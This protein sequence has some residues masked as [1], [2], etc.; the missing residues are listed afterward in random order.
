MFVPDRSRPTSAV[1]RVAGRAGQLVVRWTVTVAV[2]GGFL[3]LLTALLAGQARNFVTA[4]KAGSDVSKIELAPLATRSI[5]YAADGSVIQYLY[6]EQDRLPVSIDKVPPQVVKAVLDAEDDRFFQHGPIDLRAMARAMV[7]NVEAGQIAE[8]GSTITQQL[9]KTALLTPKKNVSRKLQEASLA[10]RLEKQMTKTQILERYLNTVYFG[11]G[12]YGLEAAA[13]VYYQTNV[14]KL[15]QGQG[16]LLAG[17]IRNPVG[18]DPFNNPQAARDRRDAIIDRMV[19]LGDV[20]PDQAV[21]LKAEPLPTPPPAPDTGSSDYF[22]RKVVDD[23]LKDPKYLG[24]TDADRNSLVFRGGISIHTT[25][26]PSAQA[27]AEASITETLPE[28][29][30]QFDAAL[31]SVDPATGAVRAA[32]SGLDFAKDKINLVTGAGRQVGSAFKTF[33][34]M[35]A[36][37]AGDIPADTILGTSPCSIPNP[38]GEDDPWKTQN[39]EG[40]SAG[41]LSLTDATA[42]SVNCAYARL[43]KLLGPDKVVD[44]AKRM[45]VGFSS[46]T[47]LTPN[48]SLTLGTSDVT[49]LDMASA[50][51]TL[52]ADGEHHEPYFIDRI[53]DRNGKVIYKT[54]GKADRAVSVQNAR[55][56]V[57]VL[58]QVVQRGTGTAA[59]VPGWTVAGKTGSTDN[60]TDGW[61]VGFTPK[62]ATAVWMGAPAGKVPMY[63]VGIFPKVFGGTY[64]AMIFSDFM[65]KALD[66]QTPVVFTAPDRVPNQRAPKTLVLPNEP[67]FGFVDRGSTATVPSRD[68]TSS[69]T[70][71]TPPASTP[72]PTTVTKPP[73]TIPDIPVIT[74]PTIP[75]ITIPDITVP[76]P[77]GTTPTTRRPRG[78]T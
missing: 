19:V 57:S 15:T 5:L 64:P 56:V 49:P 2:A 27:Q 12:A 11:N 34:L 68:P 73:A 42:E 71:T 77:Q 3:A 33:T 28:D 67:A 26:L 46:P 18:A 66:G 65:T 50:Y 17:L 31:V 29:R 41:L 8:G 40:E 62:L 63:N 39:N 35:A 13:E 20:T 45:G 53:E 60:N 38:G 6:G 55:T 30:G 76:A 59:A 58:Q 54:S 69:P 24:G 75:D 47:P 78:V 51:A 72:Q 52:A 37:E 70:P 43:I 74:R 61:F 23:L 16:V 25:L 48:L 4:G 9:V 1:A 32:V 10:I 7:S 21:E 14:D 44:V 22:T 36:L